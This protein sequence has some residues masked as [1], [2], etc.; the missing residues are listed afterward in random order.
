MFARPHEHMTQPSLAA[1]MNFLF[2]TALKQVLETLTIL[3]PQGECK[4]RTQAR[5]IFRQ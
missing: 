1:C 5:T 3:L 2:A 4:S